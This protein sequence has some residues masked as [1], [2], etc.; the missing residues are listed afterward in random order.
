MRVDDFCAGLITAAF[1]VLIGALA[2]THF[3]LETAPAPTAIAPADAIK[4]ERYRGLPP[5]SLQG[6]RTVQVRFLEGESVNRACGNLKENRAMACTDGN[7]IVAENPCS[8][9]AR[10]SRYLGKF[11]PDMQLIIYDPN[12]YRSVTWRKTEGMFFP[13]SNY[14]K[15]RYANAMALWDYTTMLCH[16]LG[17]TNGWP[18]NHW[19]T[20]DLP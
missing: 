15:R 4:D 10:N 13:Y 5:L 7:T 3:A 1:L 18:G 19:R 14:T 8:Y 6:A 16:E 11:D 20:K 9:V 17:H 12:E 2:R